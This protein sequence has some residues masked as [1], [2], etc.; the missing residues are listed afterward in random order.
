MVFGV[1]FG[2]VSGEVSGNLYVVGVR[3]NVECSAAILTPRD[4][5]QT[6]HGIR[7]NSKVVSVRSREI[8]S[9]PRPQVVL[10]IASK[11]TPAATCSGQRI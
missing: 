5:S 3:S 10:H 8:L 6:T 4:D 1:E 2:A 9:P 11:T 7:A